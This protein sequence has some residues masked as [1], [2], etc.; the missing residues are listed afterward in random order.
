MSFC[1]VRVQSGRN[2]STEEIGTAFL[3]ANFLLCLKPYLK[4]VLCPKSTVT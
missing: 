3:V 2:Q 1:R 4:L